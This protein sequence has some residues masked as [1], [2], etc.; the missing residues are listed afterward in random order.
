MRIGILGSGDVG[1]VLGAGFAKLGHTVKMGTRN[2]GQDKIKAWIAKAGPGASAGT[3]AEAASF[4]E[5]VVLCTLWSGTEEAIRLAEPKNLAEKVVI[6][7]TNPLDF[8]AG[9]PP[10]LAMYLRFLS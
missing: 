6:D 8:S 5:V 4:G 2:P 1:Q 10:K 7:A 9:G 3:F